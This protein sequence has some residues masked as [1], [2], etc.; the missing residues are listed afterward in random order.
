MAEG[1]LASA[2]EEVQS[3]RKGDMLIHMA[4]EEVRGYKLLCNMVVL[5]QLTQELVS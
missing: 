1:G 5:L 3:D 4:P 2:A